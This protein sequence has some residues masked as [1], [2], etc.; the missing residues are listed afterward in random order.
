MVRRDKPVYMGKD[1]F[2]NPRRPFERKKTCPACGWKGNLET[3]PR[4]DHCGY[5]WPDK[6]VEPVKNFYKGLRGVLADPIVE[7]RRKEAARKIASAEAKGK[8]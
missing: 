5:Y 1:E 2:G 6:V 7:A 8:V 4:C 3:Q